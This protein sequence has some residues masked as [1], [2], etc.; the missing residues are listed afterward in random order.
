[1]CRNITELR[2]LQPAATAEEI[3]AAA[4]QYVRK[5]SGITRP[6]AANADV[7]ETA[8]AEVTEATTRL[9]AALPPRRQPPKTVPPLRR[10][11]V[12]ARLAG[13]K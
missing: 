6:S 11:E 9:L 7:F 3:G 10:P 8:V 5:V 2:G 13:A 12:M 4:R 1:M